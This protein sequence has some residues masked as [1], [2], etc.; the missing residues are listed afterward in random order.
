MI[1]TLAIKR[2]W[3]KIKFPPKNNQKKIIMTISMKVYK[4]A[5]WWGKDSREELWNLLDQR[6][7]LLRMPTMEPCQFRS[8]IQCPLPLRLSSALHSNA[9]SR[10]DTKRSDQTLRRN[11]TFPCSAYSTPRTTLLIPTWTRWLTPTTMNLTTWSTIPWRCS[12][13]R[14]AIPSKPPF[15][16]L[17]AQPTQLCLS[18]K[19]TTW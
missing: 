18:V 2:T 14:R 16:L 10:A 17:S 15:F 7:K 4:K 5:M 8:S 1:L 19:L 12:T 11:S 6:R 3:L 9:C 13:R